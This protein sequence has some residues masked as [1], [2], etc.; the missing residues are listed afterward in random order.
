MNGDHEHAQNAF[1]QA[2]LI[3]REA[4]D[5]SV[6]SKAREESLSPVLTT[7][8]FYKLREIERARLLLSPLGF[9]PACRFEIGAL[10]PLQGQRILPHMGCEKGQRGRLQPACHLIALLLVHMMV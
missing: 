6:A 3:M 4:F 8:I 1:E 7:S 2:E 5:P 9:P 10:Q